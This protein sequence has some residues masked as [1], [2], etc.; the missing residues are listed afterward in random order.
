MR[1]ILRPIQRLLAAVRAPTSQGVRVTDVGNLL[2]GHSNTH[3][4]AKT[5]LDQLS[6]SIRTFHSRAV[7][8]LQGQEIEDI[9]IFGPFCA[10]VLLENSCAALVGRLDAFRMLY[11]SEFQSQPEYDQGKRART[12]FAWSGDVM[13][14]ERNSSALWGMDVDAPKVSRALF[15]RHADHVYWKP[16]VDRMLDFVSTISEKD[17]LSEVLD[18]DPEHFIDGARGR[19]AQLYSTLSKGVHWEFFTS[20]LVFDELT[21]KTQIRDTLLLIGQLGLAS[22]F[23]PTAYASLSNDVAVNTYVAFRKE[24]Q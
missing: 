15:S 24:M 20:V 13:P 3:G 4:I 12:A 22:H 2:C 16:A 9:T 10:R 1:L 7:Q 5:A 17:G 11:L 18:L 21:V 8:Y 23:I 19:S 6:R 14:D